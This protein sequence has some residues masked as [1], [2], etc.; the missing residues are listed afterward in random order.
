MD[1]QLS[2]NLIQAAMHLPLLLGSGREQNERG[3][4][5][6]EPRRARVPYT[7]DWCNFFLI[8]AVHQV[9]VFERIRSENVGVSTLKTDKDADY[10]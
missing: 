7:A 1:E 10:S 6:H 8:R 4:D 9:M 3:C 2:D 5:L